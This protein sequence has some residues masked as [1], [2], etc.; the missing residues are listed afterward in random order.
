MIVKD[1]S[2]VILETLANLTSYFKFDYYAISDTGSSDDTKDKIS[3]FFKNAGVPGEIHDDPWKDFGHNRTRAFE[4]AYKKTDYALVWDADDSIV[5]DFKLPDELTYDYYMFTF[6]PGTVYNRGQLFNNHKRWKYVGVLHEFVTCIDTAGPSFSVT[7]NYHFISGKTGNRSKNPNKYLDDAKVLEKAFYESYEAKDGLHHRYAFYTAQSYKSC[8]HH[9]EAIEWYKKV[10]TLDGWIQEKYVSCLYINE[11]YTSLK[12]AEEGIYYLIESYKYDPRRVEGIYQLIQYY[13]IKGQSNIAMAFYT[14]IQNYFENEY[15][16]DN[17]ASRLF[18]NASEYDFF[19]P[20]YMIIVADR[21]KRPDIAITMYSMIFQQGYIRSG[22]WWIH[23]LFTNIQFS[24]PKDNAMFVDHMVSYIHKLRDAGIYIKYERYEILDTIVKANRSAIGAPC[25]RQIQPKNTNPRI[26]LTITTCKRLELFEETMNSVLRTWKD[27]DMVDFFFCVDDN[28]SEED[29]VKMQ[30]TYPFFNYYMKTPSEKGHRESMNIIWNKLNELKPTYWIHLEDDWLYMTSESY[31]SRGI[32]LLDKYENQNIH[33]L[34][35]NREYGIRI[36]DLFNVSGASLEKGAWVHKY[37]L[38]EEKWLN[39]NYWKHYSMQPSIVRTRVILELGNY[40]SANTFFEGD[41]ANKY[42]AA[43]Y[44]TMFFDGIYSTHIGKQHWE[45]EGKNAYALNETGQFAIAKSGQKEKVEQ[46][47]QPLSEH[48]EQPQSEHVE[49]PLSEQPPS[50]QPLQTTDIVTQ[51]LDIIEHVFD[52]NDSTNNTYTFHEIRNVPLIGTMREHLDQILYKIQHTIPFGL[53]RPSDGEHHV[54]SN[55]TLTNC[56]NWTFNAGGILQKQLLGAIQTVDPNLYIGIPCNTCNAPWNCT[57]AIYDDFTVNWKVPLA[58]RT[59]ANLFMGA[60]WKPFINFLLSYKRGLFVITSGTRCSELPIQGRCIIDDKLVNRWDTEH[61][62]ET[63]RV[64]QF[65]KDKKGELICFSAGPLSKYWIPLCMK[66]NPSNMYIDVG[67][68]L[69]IFTKGSTNRQYTEPNSQFANDVCRFEPLNPF[70]YA[71]ITTMNKNLVYMCVFHNETYMDLLSMLMITVK[72][73]SRVD[74]MDFLVFTSAEFVQKIQRLSECIGI[75]IRTHIFAFTTQHEAGCARLYLYE[76]PGITQYEKILYIDTDIIVQNDIT[77]L[78]AQEIEDKIYALGEETIEKEWMGGWFFDF[79]TIDRATPGMNSGILLFNNKPFVRTL[80]HEIREHVRQMK[81]VNSLMPECMDQPFIN[82]HIIRQNKHNTTLLNPYAQLFAR[83]P[84]PFPTKPTDAILCHFAWP[85]GKADHKRQRMLTYLAHLFNHY[86]DLYTSECAD[87]QLRTKFTW[88]KNGFIQFHATGISTTW[89][90]GSYKW[91]DSHTVEVTWHSYS[92]ILRMNDDYTS[93]LSIRKSDCMFSIETQLSNT[94]L[95]I[96]KKRNLIYFSVFLDNE[97]FEQFKIL[98]TTI[99]LFSKTDTFDFLVI[100]STEM[101]PKIQHL[102]EHMEIPIHIHYQTCN[103]PHESSSAK[104]CIFEY[105]DINKYNK[106]LYIDTDIIVQNDISTIFTHD[107]EDKIYAL[108]EATIERQHSGGWFFDF[109][110]IDKNTTALNGGILLFKNTR[111]TQSIFNDCITHICKMK[112]A[113]ETMPYCYEQPFLNYHI[114][115][116][117][118][119]DIQFLTQYAE[120]HQENPPPLPVKP[121]SIIFCHFAGSVGFSSCKSKRMITYMTHVFNHYSDLYTSECADPQLRTKFTWGTN[122]CIQFHATGISTTWGNGSYKWLDSHTVEVTWHSY[123]HILR[124]NDDYTSFLSIRKSDFIYNTEVH[125][126]HNHVGI[127]RK[128]LVYMCVFHNEAYLELLKILLVTMRFFSQTDTFDILVFT[129]K[130][131]VEKVQQLSSSIGLTIRVHT[132]TFSSFQEA[133]YA[134]LHIFEYPHIVHYEKILYIDTDIIV[135][136]DLS[137]LF[138]IEIENKVYALPEGTIEHEYHGGWFFD[139]TTID[140]DIPGM[141]SG[142]LLFRN[143]IGIRKIFRDILNHIHSTTNMPSCL[144]QPFINYHIIKHAKQDTTLLTKYAQIYC[145]DPPPPPSTPTDIILCHFVWPIGNAQHKRQRMIQHMIHVFTHYT[146]IYKRETRASN[147]YNTY[148]W[149]NNGTIRFNENGTLTTTW[150][151]GTYTWLDSRTISATWNTIT[152]ILRMNPEYSSFLSAR[153]GDFDIV[154]G[155]R[156]GRKHLVYFSVFYNKKYF[157]LAKLLLKSLL[158]FSTIPFD[159]LL[160][161]S[162]D[163]QAEAEELNTIIPIKIHYMPCATI[164]QAACARLHI[165]EYPNINQY[166]KILYLDTDILIKQDMI[167]IFSEPLED[168]LYGIESGTIDSINFGSQ[169]FDFSTVDRTTTGINSGTLLF[170]NC[171]AIRNLFARINAHIQG[172][173][174]VPPYALD[175]PFIN[176]HAIRDNMYNNSFLNKYVSLYEGGEVNNYE[177]ASICHFSFPIGNSDHKYARM[178][179][180][181][182]AELR[183]KRNSEPWSVNNTYKWGSTGKISFCDSNLL[184]TTWGPGTYEYLGENKINATWNNCEH[185]LHFSDDRTQCISLRTGPP[186]FI[187]TKLE[188]HLCLQEFTE[189]CHLGKKYCVDKSPFLGSHNYTYQYHAILNDVRNNVNKVLDLGVGNVMQTVTTSYKSGG[190]L[191]MWR[192]YFP[193]AIVY[194]YNI[195]N[196]EDE[197]ISIVHYNQS[198][199]TSLHTLSMIM[200][201]IDIIFDDG[202]HGDEHIIVSFNALWKCLNQ[203]GFYIIDDVHV[204]LLD[205]LMN[206]HNE[207]NII[208]AQIIKVYKGTHASDNF[209]V[210]KKLAPEVP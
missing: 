163:F 76:Y 114:I 162:P 197:R 144:D 57:Q 196:S 18:A 82:Y 190:N 90:N 186:D 189:L 111:S 42:F 95:T 168:V 210:F 58:Q 9:E 101:A 146:S 158:V 121:T 22:E 169:F 104:L 98:M 5:G 12:K 206:L 97:Y 116:N 59:Y 151:F 10:L 77:T 192:D 200:G 128:N 205:R 17:I 64:L 120:L 32:S 148:L 126:P 16:T 67:A 178:E 127:K 179:A 157:T 19:L 78:F 175:Q 185:I 93:F 141:N 172:Y 52:E 86:S 136:N 202:L 53:I 207:M 35:F 129:S 61:E 160:L 38:E 135:Q 143:T 46:I 66:H 154:H 187:L 31:I 75:P 171:M 170:N 198:D 132:F 159:I 119:Q 96:E 39:C 7:G 55:K 100:T 27:L 29:R 134:R 24:I 130:D 131:F 177:T 87:P 43:G 152:H 44:K 54:L 69:D 56:D 167:P 105:K 84:P 71:T 45:T 28:S 51:T 201:T 113:N 176:F 124:M 92:H 153:M 140:K 74:E 94:P 182:I 110:K 195:P 47:E 108:P 138:Q 209:I 174:G 23:N 6:G 34:V 193:N 1:E 72:L 50:E 208:D 3:T 142:I 68:T 106:I 65:I 79:A 33:Q 26:M 62:K 117:A 25:T 203:N 125:L 150:G 139:F 161:T 103:S 204:S 133:G 191:R 40:D 164:F 199:I 99:K 137:V 81:E 70:P 8:G 13:C 83:T 41:Y 63:E 118:K 60:N 194:G 173:T 123:S 155:V 109:N 147:I 156:N 36:P 37:T 188:T 4:H 88:G 184:Q 2:H 89:G 180:F 112:E 166:H 80:F 91:L 122:G 115:K 181:F 165:F 49:Q 183:K 11:E 21:V 20:Y 145:T 14:L 48:V 73:F 102:S 107:L 85:L 30:Q 149:N 15:R